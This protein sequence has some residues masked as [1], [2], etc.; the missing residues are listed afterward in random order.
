MDRRLLS[1]HFARVLAYIGCGKPEKASEALQ[2]LLQ[3]L[4]KLGVR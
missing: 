4:A 1:S 2:A 3:E